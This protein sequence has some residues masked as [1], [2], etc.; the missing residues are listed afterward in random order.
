MNRNCVSRITKK[1]LKHVCKRFFQ[2]LSVPIVLVVS[3]FILF[4]CNANEKKKEKI[5]VIL[6]LKHADF[7]T[8]KIKTE[9]MS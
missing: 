9:R 5:Y 3:Y 1:Y 2:C 6:Y 7:F 4:Y 8:L